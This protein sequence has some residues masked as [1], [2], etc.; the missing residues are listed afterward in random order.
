MTQELVSIKNQT[1]YP[2]DCRKEGWSHWKI[3]LEHNRS[4]VMTLLPVQIITETIQTSERSC[5][6]YLIQRQ[7]GGSHNAY[8]KQES[9]LYLLLKEIQL[10]VCLHVHILFT[11]HYAFFIF[12]LIEKM[13][14][15]FLCRRVLIYLLND[16]R[17]IRHRWP[18]PWLQR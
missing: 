18:V 12:Y 6:L 17:P 10:F 14:E 16:S 4:H 9:S 5:S 13:S 1:L 7:I 15:S 2:R 3:S 11:K 8:F